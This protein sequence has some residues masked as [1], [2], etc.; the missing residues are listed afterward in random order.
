MY[1][2]DGSLFVGKFDHGRAQGDGLYVLPDGSYFEGYVDDNVATCPRGVFHCKEYTYTGGFKNNCFEG[3]G[4]EIA[5][6]YIF[7]GTYLKGVRECGELKWW[8]QPGEEN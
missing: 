6:N 1:K 3:E 4:E 7:K 5:E 8:K 2:S